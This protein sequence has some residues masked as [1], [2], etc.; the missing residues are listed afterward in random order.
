MLVATIS[1]PLVA[2]VTFDL[3]YESM[4]IGSLLLHSAALGKWCEYLC[5]CCIGTL[6]RNYIIILFQPHAHT[7]VFMAN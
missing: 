4:N 2:V 3:I 7:G 5:N 1:Q 6:I